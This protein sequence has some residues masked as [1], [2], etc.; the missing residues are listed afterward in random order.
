MLL[1]FSYYLFSVLQGKLED[2]CS[3]Y[4]QAIAIEKG[5]EHSQTL[6]LLFAQFSRFIFLVYF[7]FHSN[8]HCCPVGLCALSISFIYPVIIVHY[9]HTSCIFMHLQIE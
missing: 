9:S 6:P 4:E 1:S 3:L 8:T 2:A 7:V 5:K